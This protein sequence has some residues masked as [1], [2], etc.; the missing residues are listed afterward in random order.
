LA[1]PI[2]FGDRVERVAVELV[3]LT[4]FIVSNR[5]RPGMLRYDRSLSP[6]AELLRRC[7]K[8]AV[9]GVRS[10][11]AAFEVGG[12]QLGQLLSAA[13]DVW[14]SNPMML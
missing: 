10:A 6:R 12:E 1:S 7:S 14:K 2:V 9:A 11:D 3:V 13:V 4:R 5:R 8:H